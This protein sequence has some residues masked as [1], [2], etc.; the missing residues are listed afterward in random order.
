MRGAWTAVCRILAPVAAEYG[1]ERGREV[2]SAVTDEELDV[3]EPLVEGQGEVGP[4]APSIP[5]GLAVTPPRCIRRVPCS[6]NTRT[7]TLLS[8]AVSTC[9]KSTATIP[10]AWAFKNCRQVVPARRGA[11]SMPAARKISQTVDGATVT[12]SF[13]SSPWIR[14]CR[15]SGF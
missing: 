12:P 3:L 8:S 11:G 14:P 9:R 4:A 5:R 15:H 6:M 13:I 10:E 7:Y 1:V 2:R